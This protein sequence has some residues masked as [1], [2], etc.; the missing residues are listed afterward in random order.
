MYVLVVFNRV[1][2]SKTVKL[3]MFYM[4]EYSTNFNRHIDTAVFMV[5]TYILKNL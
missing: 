1:S 3:P 4:R 2:T 5:L